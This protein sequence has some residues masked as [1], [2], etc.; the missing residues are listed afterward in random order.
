ML[1]VRLLTRIPVMSIALLGCDVTAA[2]EFPSKPIRV[3]TS[4]PGGGSDYVARQVAQGISGPLGQQVIIE[5]RPG[6]SFAGEAVSRAAPDGYTL[7]YYGSALWLLP[8]MRKDVP[9]DTVRD[10]AP[11]TLTTIQPNV[12]VVHPTLPVKNVKDLIALAKARPRELNYAAGGS[13]SSGHLAAEMFK[14][15]AKLDIVRIPY[16]GQGPATIDLVAGQIQL[17]FG[18]AGSVAAHM[19]SGRLRAL[20]V[21]TAEPSAL[22]PGLPT[23]AA[24]G[25][26]GYEAAQVSG[27]LAP[28]RTPAALINRLNLEIVRFLTRPEVKERMFGTGVEVVASTPEAFGAKIKSEISRMGKIIREA[29]IRDE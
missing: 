9:Y 13:G 8:L 1:T 11:I 7:I 15:M 14:N 23:I 5:N 2:Q 26:P 22:V 18:T 19:K 6:G 17:T 16:K 28:A 12:L 25:V 3:M 10:F 21:T 20:A 29:N 4:P 27:L 24:S